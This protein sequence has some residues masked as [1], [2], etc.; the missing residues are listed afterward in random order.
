MATLN[1]RSAQ[2]RSSSS[3]SIHRPIYPGR[4]IL[5]DSPATHASPPLIDLMSSQNNKANLVKDYW[6]QSTPASTMSTLLSDTCTCS[7]STGT[8]LSCDSA[9]SYTLSSVLSPTLSTITTERP[10]TYLRKSAYQ[11]PS[12]GMYPAR[13]SDMYPSRGGR[14]NVP[15][16]YTDMPPPHYSAPSPDPW[17]TIGYDFSKKPGSSTSSQSTERPRHNQRAT[18]APQRL[19]Q[20]TAWVMAGQGVIL[21]D[22]P[23][24]CMRIFP[25]TG[26]VQTDVG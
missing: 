20:E 3:S 9:T 15:G 16:Y 6:S 11:Y 22:I 5:S 10:N 23:T 17:P 14:S 1:R 18:D 24:G 12:R 25:V 8:F 26:T 19:H 13:G 21:T 4:K 2:S 7:S